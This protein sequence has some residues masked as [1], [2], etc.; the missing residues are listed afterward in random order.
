MKNEKGQFWKTLLSRSDKASTMRFCTLIVTISAC[1]V[2][3]WAV[4]KGSDLSAAGVLVGAMLGTAFTGKALQRK[5]EGEPIPD[6]KDE[7]PENE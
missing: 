1:A 7:G 2:A 6:K 4:H 3:L 5:F